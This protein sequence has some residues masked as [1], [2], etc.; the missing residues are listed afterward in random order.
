VVEYLKEENRLLKERL[1]GRGLDSRMPNAVDPHDRS[2]TRACDVIDAA[3]AALRRNVTTPISAI[4][5]RKA[6]IKL[7]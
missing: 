1:R 7:A 6:T 4:C 3:S 5:E 2:K